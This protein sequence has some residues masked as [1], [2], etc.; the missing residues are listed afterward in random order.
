MRRSIRP[1]QVNYRS[2]YAPRSLR[3]GTNDGPVWTWVRSRARATMAGRGIAR[4]GRTTPSARLH[5]AGGRIWLSADFP[6]RGR[7]AGD[8]RPSH[9]NDHSE[10]TPVGDKSPPHE[11]HPGSTRSPRGKERQ[12]REPD[13]LPLGRVRRG[14]GPS[15]HSFRRS[16]HRVVSFTESRLMSGFLKSSSQP[17]RNIYVFLFE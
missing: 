13:R 2:K 14:A 6:L 17:V 7:A 16:G 12:E 3:C 4:T 8:Y 11:I 15:S 5:V 9:R 1:K 10:S